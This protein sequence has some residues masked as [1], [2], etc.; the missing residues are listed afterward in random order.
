VNVEKVIYVVYGTVVLLVVKPKKTH[1]LRSLLLKCFGS[2]K[3]ADDPYGFDDCDWNEWLREFDKFLTDKLNS[4]EGRPTYD[5]VLFDKY[6]WHAV[7]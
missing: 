4:N 1:G 2:R 3:A 6:S 5:I 7:S